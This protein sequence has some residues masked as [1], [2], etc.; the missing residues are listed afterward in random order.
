MIRLLPLYSSQN[1][2]ISAGSVKIIKM[3]P[4]TLTADRS[5]E[6]VIQLSDFTS[7]LHTFSYPPVCVMGY[8]H[9]GA[10]WGVPHLHK[11]L[12]HLGIT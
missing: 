8:P 12:K 3:T 6:G 7:Q 9:R 2:V 5:K 10:K 11:I 4:D 1:T